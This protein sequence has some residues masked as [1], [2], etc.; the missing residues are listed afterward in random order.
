MTPSDLVMASHNNKNHTQWHSG[1]CTVLEKFWNCLASD[2]PQPLK[3]KGKPE[4]VKNLTEQITPLGPHWAQKLGKV[5]PREKSLQYLKHPKQPPTKHNS[6]LRRSGE[7][8][9]CCILFTVFWP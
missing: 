9:L 7:T 8:V 4:K 5:P 2:P 6:C 1:E 3:T